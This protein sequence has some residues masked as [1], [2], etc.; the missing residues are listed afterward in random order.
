MKK[1][2]IVGATAALLAGI[3]TGYVLAAAEGGGRWEGKPNRDA[4]LV[5]SQSATTDS[6]EFE[7]IPGLSGA[8]LKNRGAFSISF[9]G[10]FS[11]GP[12][13]VRIP[14]AKPG[15]VAFRRTGAEPD[16]SSFTFVDNAGS[17]ATCSTVDLEW[18]SL[19]GTPVSLE[20]GSVVISYHY[21]GDKKAS[22]I[23]CV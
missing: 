11:G 1:T 21:I 3:V 6:V 8:T 20:K 13:E 19:D 10:E 23:G 22:E 4:I 5:R 9:S 18:R 17:E 12:V 7:N 15:A 14:G 2:A 16:S